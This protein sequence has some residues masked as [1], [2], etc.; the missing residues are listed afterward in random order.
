MEMKADREQR[1]AESEWMKAHFGLATRR[2]LHEMEHRIMSKLSDYLAAQTAFNTR[3]G[4]A[5]D[6]LVTSVS[7]LTGDVKNLNA[8]IAALQASQGTVSPEDQ[9]TID[10]LQAAGTALADRLD[11]VSAALAALDAQTPPVV[12]PPAPA[13]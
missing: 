1:K 11:G 8:Q 7:G 5:V 10:S 2:D 12:P 13:G 4:A 3:Q 9:A 6:S